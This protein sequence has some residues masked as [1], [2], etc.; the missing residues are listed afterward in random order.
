[1][2]FIWR[3]KLGENKSLSNNVWSSISTWMWKLASD[4]YKDKRDVST[5]KVT[6]KGK[7]REIW[8]HKTVSTEGLEDYK[9][10]KNVDPI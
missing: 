1:M 4:E 3:I 8:G 6:Q 10:Q 9:I 7:F 2:K 5:F